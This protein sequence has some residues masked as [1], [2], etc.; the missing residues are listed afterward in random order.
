[1]IEPTDLQKYLR[2]YPETGV[3]VWKLRTPET[4]P[5]WSQARIAAWNRQFSKKRA[6]TSDR[7]YGY[8]GGT[9]LGQPHYA[10]RVA[11]AMTYGEWPNHIDHVNGDSADNRIDN[12]RSVQPGEN[13]RNRKIPS[14]SPFGVMG[15]HQERKNTYVATLG[16]EVIGRFRTV[17]EAAAA[18]KAAEE[19][20]GGY[21][22]NHG[23]R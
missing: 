12:L 10:H 16:S 15:V 11:W 6:L 9:L 22:H 5:D 21:H 18:R 1:M 20:H 23:K 2:Y 4:M 8:K 13:L 3:F 19:A 7:T 17:E 14:N